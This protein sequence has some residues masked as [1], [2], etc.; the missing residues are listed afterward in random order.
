MFAANPLSCPSG[1]LRKRA[2]G[3]VL[4]CVALLVGTTRAEAQS[5]PQQLAE[6]NRAAMDAYNNLDVDGAK[7]L[8]EQ[9]AAGAERSGIRGAALARTYANLAVVLI[10]TGD[11][12]GAV[13]QFKRALQEDSKVEPDPLVATPEVTAAY[14]EAKADA[15]A[16]AR[17]R[18]RSAPPP[19]PVAPPEGNLDHAPVP[20]Q[21]VQTAVP[22]FVK[23]SSEL[24]GATLKIFYRSLGMPRPR[25]AEMQETDDGFTYLIPCGDVFEPVVEYFIVALDASGAQLGNSGTPAKP[26]KVPVVSERTQVAPSLPGQVPPAQCSAGGGDDAGAVEA[27]AEPEPRPTGGTG[28]GQT[29]SRSSDCAEGLSCED[30]FCVMTAAQ[31]DTDHSSGEARRFF[32]EVNFGVGATYVGKGR[33]PDHN[34]PSTTIERVATAATSNEG[35]LDTERAADDLRREGWD[36]ATQAV[37]K[38]DVEGDVLRLSQCTVAVKPGGF[39]AV[40]V[41]NLAAGYYLAPRFAL[42]LTGRI[43]FARGQGV[44]AGVLIGARGEFLLTQPVETGFRMSLVGGVSMGQMQARPPAE[45]TRRGPFATNASLGPDGIAKAGAAVTAGV[46]TTYRFMPSLGFSFMPALH[47]GLPNTLWDLDVIAGAELAF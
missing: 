28:L 22:V 25:S 16:A 5:S 33:A 17:P 13:T 12:S 42:A 15:P 2:L 20:E 44:L 38:E 18:A 4:L 29:C 34:P 46:R 21:L 3:C 30:N 6:A 35:A 8:L 23:K 14:N 31:D 19:A 7:T 27:S 47:V 26:V 40:P 45:G 39:V 10:S 11:K 1:R 36:C 32:V 43:Q 24:G 41:L 37:Q 9:A